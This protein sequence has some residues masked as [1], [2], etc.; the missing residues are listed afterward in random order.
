MDFSYAL[1]DL[2]ELLGPKKTIGS[3]S[4]PVSRINT[5]S[6]AKP[7]DVSFLGNLKYKRDVSSTE[8][9]VVL[10]PMDFDAHPRDGQCFMFF[11]N[12]SFALGILCRDI[13]MKCCPRRKP[14]IHRTAVVDET[15]S[16]GS[17]VSIGANV[18]VEGN[19][20][21]GS[22]VVIMAGCYVGHGVKIGANSVL[23]PGVKVMDFCEIGARVTLFPGVVVGSDGFGYETVNGI[24][25]KIP[26][27]GNVVIGDDVDIGANSTIDR[28]RFGHTNI[29]RGTKIDNLVQIGHNVSVGDGCLIVS[30]TGISGSTTIGNYVIIGGQVGIAGH[31]SIPDGIMIA[32]K[33]SVPG[34]KKRDGEI[35]RGSPTMPLKEAN[36]FYVLRTKIP[37]LFKRVA[38]LEKILGVE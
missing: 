37:D 15:A 33:S 20:A 19:V 32:G 11:D 9:S 34:Y 8:A 6:N 2:I 30:Q 24:H 25:E 17:G 22:G 4:V 28:A 31:I 14:G 10:L 29:G 16:V 23:Q 21:I 3:S 13:E 18:V 1:D 12:S 27:V 5:L 26:Q 35:L 7:G 36:H 38:A